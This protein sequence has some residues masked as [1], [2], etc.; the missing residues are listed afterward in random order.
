VGCRSVVLHPQRSELKEAVDPGEHI[1]WST[2]ALAAL[3][4]ALTWWVVATDHIAAHTAYVLSGE[5]D[6]A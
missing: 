6:S 2:R 1:G 5:E 3:A 4:S